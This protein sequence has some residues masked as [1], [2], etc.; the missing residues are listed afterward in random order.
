[1]KRYFPYKNKNKRT[2]NGSYNSSHRVKNSNNKKPNYGS[3]N[4]KV[5][6]ERPAKDK[7]IG[8]CFWN[9]V[10][11]PKIKYDEYI[12]EF[13]N[14]KNAPPHFHI[15]RADGYQKVSGTRSPAI[16]LKS[17]INRGLVFG[18]REHKKEAM[19][20]DIQSVEVI[21]FIEENRLLI[22]LMYYALKLGKVKEFASTDEDYILSLFSEQELAVLIDKFKKKIEGKQTHTLEGEKQQ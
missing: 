7:Y 21:E 3:V 20:N 2:I 5:R 6:L 22:Y 12:V 17:S 14:H 16:T 13:D 8:D 18:Y 19:L 9:K 11:I 1:M 10:T 15:W 4:L